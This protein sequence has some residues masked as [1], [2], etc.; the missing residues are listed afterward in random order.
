M[1]EDEQINTESKII[2]SIE[3]QRLYY[4]DWLR[5]LAIFMVFVYHTLRIFG[6]NNEIVND[7]NYVLPAEVIEWLILPFGMPLFFI[8]SGMSVFYGVEYM[9]KKGIAKITFIKERTLRLFVPYLIA[10]LTYLSIIVALFRTVEGSYTLQYSIY[11]PRNYINFYF[12]DYFSLE[13]LQIILTGWHLWFLLILLIFNLILYKYFTSKV[14]NNNLQ[15]KN[16]VNKETKNSRNIF[17]LLIPF[18]LIEIVNPFGL[19]TLPRVGG[20]DTVNFFL[21]FFL[22]F[23]FAYNG[24]FQQKLEKA[25]KPALIIGNTTLILRVLEFFLFFNGIFKYR[26]YNA[27][28]YLYWALFVVNGWSMMIVILYYFSKFLNRDHKYRKKLNE[29][30]MPFYILHYIVLNVVATYALVFF[31]SYPMIAI[32]RI[33][34][35]L[36]LSFIIIV[37]LCLLI[38]K[39]KVLRPIFGMRMQSRKS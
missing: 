22:G 28:Y 21:F 13:N 3:K 37:G 36:G 9:K 30:V 11:D 34:V 27:N 2:K 24:N 26:L 16:Q 32:V 10:I 38:A 6:Q 18:Y 29:I 8:I 19:T 20:W 4:L 17:L 31:D 35:I 15:N 33:I 1:T 23:R 25:I 39:I 14:F 5:I 12:T 7:P